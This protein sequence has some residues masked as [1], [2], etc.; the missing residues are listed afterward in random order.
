M[1]RTMER[2]S[3]TI[4]GLTQELRQMHL[5][6]SR[7]ALQASTQTRQSRSM[8]RTSGALQER[9]MEQPH[10]PVLAQ[11]HRWQQEGMSLRA[12]VAKL[13]AEGIPTRSRQ[14]KWYQSNLSRLLARTAQRLASDGG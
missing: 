1:Q 8:E 14:G 3:D 13:N 11:I 4:E 6:R 7:S 2:L 10:D 9:S 12:I 5:E